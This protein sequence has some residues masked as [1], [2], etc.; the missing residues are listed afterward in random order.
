MT[1]SNSLDA[2]LGTWLSAGSPTVAELSARSGFDWLLIDLEHGSGSESDVLHQFRAMHGGSVKA[3]VR[4]GAPHPEL[5]AR[6]LDWGADGI[7]VPH[8]E[9]A[10]AAKQCV[11]AMLYPPRGKRG[12]ARYVRAFGYGRQSPPMGE[13]APSDPIFIA[14]IET[15]QAVMNAAS[16]AAVDGVSVLFIGPADLQ[17]SLRAWPGVTSLDYEGCLKHVAAAAKAA[18][19]PCGILLKGPEDLRRHL[20]FGYSWLAVGSDLGIL[21]Q[22]HQRIVEA[23]QSERSK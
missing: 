12:V 15:P 21:A 7:M 8:V 14:Q 6:L 17:T 2:Q 5:I 10:E 20:D 13:Q 19:K 22:G 4:V 18:D 11:E 1:P 9:S 23:W 16:I 3:I